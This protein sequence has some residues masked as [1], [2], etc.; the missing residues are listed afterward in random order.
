MIS[1]QLE[2]RL[3]NQLFQYAFAHATSKKLGVSFYLDKSIEPLLLYRYFEIK[4][5]VFYVL[6]KY[7]FSIKG[8][9]N[10]FT[11]Y[12]RKGF[13]NSLR[14]FL[15]LTKVDIEDTEIQLFKIKNHTIM[16]GFFQSTAYFEPY[17][18]DIQKFFTIKDKYQQEFETIFNS[19]PNDKMLIVVH[20]R[21]T[22]YVG[23]NL[24]LPL[25]YYEEA[26]ALDSPDQRHYIFIS[27]DPSF[28]EEQFADIQNKYVSKQSEIIDLQF[29][30]HADVCILSN[31]S[32]SWWGAYLNKKNAKII[33]PKFWSG[34]S[35]K[36]EEPHGIT[37]DK[38]T[39]LDV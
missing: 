14:W 19:L 15:N 36:T 25:S 28:V 35:R 34:F 3:G 23:L 37:I 26:I 1:V 9:K 38:W 31:S 33:A 13:Y 39:L 10:L 18:K 17:Q 32:F 4:N 27:D 29:L 24:T 8:F 5:D 2:G 11:H 20:V 22:D 12:L 16:R 21:R 30:M 6:D 7:L